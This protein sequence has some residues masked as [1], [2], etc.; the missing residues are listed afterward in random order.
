[1]TRKYIYSFLLLTLLSVDKPVMAQQ[2]NALRSFRLSFMKHLNYPQNMLDSCIATA[3][4]LR[5]SK[6]KSQLS[7]TLSDSAS[8]LFKQEFTRVVGKLNTDELRLSLSNCKDDFSILIPVYYTFENNYC[9]SA[10][11]VSLL[12]SSFSRFNGQF[13]TGN[14]KVVEPIVVRSSKPIIN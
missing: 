6:V 4:I 10:I 1:M 3:T 2:D 7:F 14:C 12:S 9:T 8:E 5:I 11:N 13:Y